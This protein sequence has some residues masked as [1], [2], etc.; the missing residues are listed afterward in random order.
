MERLRLFINCCRDHSDRFAAAL[1]LY[2]RQI[3]GRSTVPP[4]RQLMDRAEVEN[5]RRE[6]VELEA[7]KRDLQESKQEATA[8]RAQVAS[9]R[10]EVANL[11]VE[12]AAMANQLA[13]S[14]AGAIVPA[15]GHQAAPV[16]GA[17]AMVQASIALPINASQSLVPTQDG[18]AHVSALVGALAAY[19]Y[20]A[21]MRPGQ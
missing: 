2:F 19:N 21:T 9:L 16:P 6:K 5:L 14:A 15:F 11:K 4:L 10:E 1:A 18:Q 20:L 13:N 12:K 3:T 17:S 7:A 8:L